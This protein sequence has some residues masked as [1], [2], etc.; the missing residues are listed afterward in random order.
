MWP[1]L[2]IRDTVCHV[3]D[4]DDDGNDGK[5][6]DDGG[7]NDGDDAK[8]DDTRNDV[9]HFYKSQVE[10]K[11]CPRE[12]LPTTIRPS[13]RICSSPSTTP[14]SVGWG[15]VGVAGSGVT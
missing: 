15:G 4:D 2:E 12:G 5:D 9:F 13:A 14:G 6:D 3:D 11:Y 10:V 8:N 7:S 1:T